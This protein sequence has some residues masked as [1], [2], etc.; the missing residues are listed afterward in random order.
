MVEMVSGNLRVTEKKPR[1]RARKMCRK[2]T[3]EGDR[4]SSADSVVDAPN[5][6]TGAG[7]ATGPEVG[8]P[9]IELV[10]TPISSESSRRFDFVECE[11]KS[12]LLRIV[13]GSGHG[14]AAC[15]RAPRTYLRTPHHAATRA[16][17]A[18][19]RAR[20]RSAPVRPLLSALSLSAFERSVDL[21]RDAL[22]RG[23][24]ILEFR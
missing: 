1:P 18:A 22:K 15:A 6:V 17:G 5:S 9:R 7:L 20:A 23:G 12:L 24:Y 13:G 11:C 4:Y 21:P 2:K 16:P 10:E 14:A 19:P 3:R 8:E